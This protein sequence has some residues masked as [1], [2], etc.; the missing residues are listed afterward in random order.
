MIG[1]TQQQ[2]WYDPESDGFEPDDLC[3]TQDISGAYDSEGYRRNFPTI[4]GIRLYWRGSDDKAQARIDWLTVDVIPEPTT[5]SLLA[6]SGLALARHRPK[7]RRG[8]R[9]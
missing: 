3:G 5:L 2:L 6:V 8:G 4:D 7:T 1:T 9:K